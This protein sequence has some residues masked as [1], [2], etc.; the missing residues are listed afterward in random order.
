MRQY[1]Y[2]Y[3]WFFK[4]LLIVALLSTSQAFAK[5]TFYSAKELKGPWE[6]SMS[7]V[8]VSH[9]ELGGYAPLTKIEATENVKIKAYQILYWTSDMAGQKTLASG[10][11]RLRSDLFGSSK[12]IP[13]ISFQHSAR[14]VRSDGPSVQVA[15][16]EGVFGAIYHAPYGYL[17]AMPDYLGLGVSKLPQAYLNSRV[18]AQTSSDFLD[19]VLEWSQL[20]QMN[21]D[22]NLILMGYSQGGHATLALQKYLENPQTKTPFKV[23]YSVPMA[24]PYS[25]SDVS[26]FEEIKSNSASRYLF[27]AMAIYGFSFDPELEVELGEVIDPKFADIIPKVLSGEISFTEATKLLPSKANDFFTKKFLKDLFNGGALNLLRSFAKQD[28]IE[29]TPKAPVYL[30]HAPDDESVSFRNSVLA[31]KSF[32]ARGSQV[33]LKELPT[34]LGHIQVTLAAHYQASKLLTKLNPKAESNHIPQAP[35]K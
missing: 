13:V 28:L 19:A 11:V 16:P 1:K 29:W 21:I 12:K 30:F 20:M 25:V 22:T 15:D 2:S 7:S 14:F 32:Q 10:L 26:L 34:G 5:G 17:W 33:E 6:W 23:R 4:Y 31:Q 35:K 8:R 24:G 27:V 9:Q 3:Y 18:Q